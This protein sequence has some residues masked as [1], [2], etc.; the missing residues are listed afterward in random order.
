MNF[1]GKE[2]QQRFNQAFGMHFGDIND[3]TVEQVRWLVN[4]IKHCRGRC[5]NNAALNNFLSRNFTG[6]RF[7]EVQ[8]EG[9]DF[10]RLDI[11]QKEVKSATRPST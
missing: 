10:M 2:L 9:E 1:D 11:Q 3:L 5:R 4:V 8:L 6:H 7:K